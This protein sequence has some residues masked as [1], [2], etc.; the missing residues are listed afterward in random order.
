MVAVLLRVVTKF[1]MGGVK[2]PFLQQPQSH[3]P[4]SW[5]SL[6]D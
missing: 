6:Q 1:C 3:N 5:E 4:A 2:T